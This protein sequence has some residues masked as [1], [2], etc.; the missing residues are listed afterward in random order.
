LRKR[1]TTS[2]V[3]A[4]WITTCAPVTWRA[5]SLWAFAADD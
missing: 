3:E 1:N 2:Q 5:S 4:K